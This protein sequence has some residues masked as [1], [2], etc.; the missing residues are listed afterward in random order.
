MRIRFKK[1]WLSIKLYKFKVEVRIFHEKKLSKTGHEL[2][3]F[4]TI[5]KN[6]YVSY[7]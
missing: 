3:N 2:D 5:S 4:Y 6:P 1:Y 7:Y